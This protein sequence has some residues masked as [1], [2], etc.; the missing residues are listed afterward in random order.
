MKNNNRQTP[1]AADHPNRNNVRNSILSNKSSVKRNS[2]KKNKKVSI[3][4]L[5]ADPTVSVAMDPLNFW[6][7]QNIER[8]LLIEP[9][10]SQYPKS[11]YGPYHSQMETYDRT[12]EY[13]KQ[14]QMKMG[15]MKKKLYL[16]A[17]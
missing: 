13:Y 6:S 9:K 17:N 11:P 8:Y 1:A 4:G 10:F 3:G 2:M 16:E 7:P 12:V 15:A 5:D 14:I